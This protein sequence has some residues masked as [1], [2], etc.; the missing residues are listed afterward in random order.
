MIYSLFSNSPFQIERSVHG[1]FAERT[2]CSEVRRYAVVALTNLT[3]GNSSIK[4]LLCTSPSFIRVMV[5]QL[6]ED[7]NL[8]KAT[9]HLF[10]N[11]AWKPCGKSKAVL[12]ESN[13]VAVLVRAAMEVGFRAA[14]EAQEET[15]LRVILSALWNLSAHCGKNKVSAKFQNVF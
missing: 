4:S 3:F 2:P 7:E 8:R 6:A 10:R 15:T 12:S 5:R 14:A 1:D 13:V 9:A 11:L